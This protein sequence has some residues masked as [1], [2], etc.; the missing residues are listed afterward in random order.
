MFSRRSLDV[1]STFFIEFST[2]PLSLLKK[3]AEEVA[4]FSQDELSVL[5]LTRIVRQERTIRQEG[6]IRSPLI[7]MDFLLYDF[8]RANAGNAILP[9]ALRIV[10]EYASSRSEYRRII[11]R[12]QIVWFV[13]FD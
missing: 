9:A 2:F 5:T 3:N 12:E 4:Q 11:S 7:R 6:T 1:F 13:M 10:R 8:D